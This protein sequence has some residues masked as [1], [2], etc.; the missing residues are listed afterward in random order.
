MFPFLIN[1]IQITS[2]YNC[3]FL[4]LTFILFIYLHRV[5]VA[6]YG[7]FVEA[8]GILRCVAGSSLWCAGRSL[9]AVCGLS[10][11]SS[12]DVWDFSLVVALRLQGA[13][14]L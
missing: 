9:V 2:L 11:L 14:A 1:I 4:F 10:L 7:V 8:C 5:L 12:C 6:L 13:W 3:V